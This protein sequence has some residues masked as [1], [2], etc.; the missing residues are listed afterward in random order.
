MH[1]NPKYLIHLIISS[2]ESCTFV[3][4]SVEH[5]ELSE[6]KLYSQSNPLSISS[7]LI[8]HLV[9][10]FFF[11]KRYACLYHF[12]SHDCLPPPYLCIFKST[13]ASLGTSKWTPNASHNPCTLLST[14]PLSGNS[15]HT[16]PGVVKHHALFVRS[17]L[18]LI[19]SKRHCTQRK[20][21]VDEEALLNTIY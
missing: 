7:V 18:A 2:Y 17:H 1:E 11:S 9:D 5:T 21:R 8:H 19:C 16:C 4:T 3:V 20:Q 14:S 13:S 6:K 10:F 12:I 15:W